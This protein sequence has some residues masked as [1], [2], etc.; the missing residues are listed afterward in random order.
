MP[1]LFWVLWEDVLIS[2]LRH[3]F[4]V[5]FSAVRSSA[6]VS[7]WWKG[8]VLDRERTQFHMGIEREV[9]LDKPGSL[10]RA[11]AQFASRSLLRPAG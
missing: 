9:S 1:N 11:K 6:L 3:R 5:V 2:F 8:V 7:D 4:L 10:Q